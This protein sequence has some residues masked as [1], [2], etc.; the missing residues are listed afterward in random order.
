[1]G[2]SRANSYAAARVAPITT[3]SERFT[4]GVIHWLAARIPST[5]RTNRTIRLSAIAIFLAVIVRPQV[6]L[7]GDRSPKKVMGDAAIPVSGC[8][9]VMHSERRGSSAHVGL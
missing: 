3:I 5:V 6:G 4:R 8:F 9:A 2:N 1:M 7:S